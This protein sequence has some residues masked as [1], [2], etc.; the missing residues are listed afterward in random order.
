M[1]SCPVRADS[2]TASRIFI[3]STPFVRR[4]EQR[5]AAQDGVHEI[6]DLAAERH[7]LV[8]HGGRE[9]DVREAVCKFSMEGNGGVDGDAALRAEQFD[10]PA[11]LFHVESKAHLRVQHRAVLKTDE[12]G[13]EVFDVT[14]ILLAAAAC[15]NIE[16]FVF[17][18][19][20]RAQFG[21]GRAV[22]GNG[23]GFPT[24]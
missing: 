9:G 20:A 16:P 6:S 24:I 17:H 7:T 12:R 13:R 2:Y 4:R 19:V 11:V 5:R 15:G 21:E 1:T 18:V 8:N 23:R 10:A 3:I 22:N 14:D